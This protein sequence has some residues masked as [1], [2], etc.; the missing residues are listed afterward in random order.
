MSVPDGPMRS[1]PFALLGL[2]S[3]F[4]L[5][6]EELERAFRAAALRWHPDRFA[7]AS[8]EERI[9]A[10]DA[11]ASLNE[12]YERLKDPFL[13]AG[14]LLELA[15]RPLEEGNERPNDPSFLMEM[16]ELKEEVAEALA[17]A[18]PAR[19]A[20][21]RATLRDQEGREC[22]AL[23]PLFDALP[24]AG[25]ARERGLAAI[26]AQLR[27]ISYFRRT[28]EDLEHAFLASDS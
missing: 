17:S 4:H 13:R 10:E 20:R 5:D 19:M 7:R 3:S 14:A 27:R 8:A 12:A 18:D 23:G 24:E 15:G 22:E 25:P 1:G 11:M 6:A 2:P 28:R 16:L 21:I 26:H 9:D